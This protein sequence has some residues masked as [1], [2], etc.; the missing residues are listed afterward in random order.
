MVGQAATH[1]LEEI[2]AFLERG[3]QV[4]KRM[5]LHT[6]YLSEFFDICFPRC[7]L[8]IHRSV[9]TPCGEHTRLAS[10]VGSHYLV[11][12]QTIGRV[13]CC[14]DNLHIVM[15]HHTT[16]TEL[17][18]V[19]NLTVALVINLACCLR[20]EAFVD[21]EGGLQFEMRPVVK[22]V[23]EC[24]RHRL[25]PLLK[26]LPIGG[27]FS[28]AIAF[29]NTIGTHSAPFVVV[30]H[31]PDLC[32]RLEAFILGYHLWNQVAMIVNNRH[33][34]RM[35]MIEFLRSFGLQKEIFAQ[36]GFHCVAFI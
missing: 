22:R 1:R 33:F 18:V 9:G 12:F 7:R 17:R 14:A 26:P 27:V 25:C 15:L 13:V 20:I 5:N 3:G 24:V 31:K 29:V 6:A 10:G 8:D 23:A 35:L 16:R 11:P 4:C 30:A 32:N 21:T 19:L 34:G 36:K 2:V 28:C